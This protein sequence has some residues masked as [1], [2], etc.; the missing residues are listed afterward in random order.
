MIKTVR[1]VQDD[2]SA[3]FILSGPALG[4]FSHPLEGAMLTKGE[5]TL[6]MR[7]T[8]ALEKTAKQQIEF[9]ADLTGCYTAAPVVHP[10]VT[11][12]AFC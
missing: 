8:D 11:K 12:T 10:V 4:F 2:G 1:M 9:A 7:V 6:E 5:H 3:W